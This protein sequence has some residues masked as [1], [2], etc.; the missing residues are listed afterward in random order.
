MLR[1]LMEKVDNMQEQMD[2]VR[3]MMEILWKNQKKMVAIK[4]TGKRKKKC[5]WW[6]NQETEHSLG[7]I[8]WSQRFVNRKFTNQNVKRRKEKGKNW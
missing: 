5:L 1:D 6:A 2:N 8:Q 7:K 4:S 3:R